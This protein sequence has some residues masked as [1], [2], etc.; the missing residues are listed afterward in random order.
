MKETSHPLIVLLESIQASGTKGKT[1]LSKN[2]CISSTKGTFSKSLNS[3]SGSYSVLS[4]SFFLITFSAFSSFQLTA[5]TKSLRSFG[6]SFMDSAFKTL[7][8]SL[9]KLLKSLW[10]SAPKVFCNSLIRC[11]Y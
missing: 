8:N 4:L 9:L 1:F 5:L 7:S 10:T 11:L 2:D 6:L 3:V